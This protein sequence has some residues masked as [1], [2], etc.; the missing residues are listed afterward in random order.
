MT[1]DREPLWLRRTLSWVWIVT[2]TVL[3]AIGGLWS[4]SLW[5]YV[6]LLFPIWNTTPVAP[7][8]I[9]SVIERSFI[10]SALCA[11]GA[12][13]FWIGIRELKACRPKT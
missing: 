9:D 13:L 3:L 6:S 7:D 8:H 2:G 5:Y 4:L 11:I 10:V 12:V 1:L